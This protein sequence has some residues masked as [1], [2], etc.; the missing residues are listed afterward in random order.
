MLPK[1]PSTFEVIQSAL[2]AAER[3][4]QLQQ[5]YEQLKQQYSAV[6]GRY[7]F[8][9][10]KNAASDL[11]NRKFS[12]SKWEDAL[13]GMAGGNPARYQ[14]L[15]TQYKQAHSTLTTD[16][17][18]KGT[19]KNL[20]ASYTHQVQTNQTSATITTHEFNDINQHLQDLQ[21]LGQQIEDAG[22]NKNIKAA[23]D[24]NS[25]ITLEVGYIQV[26]EVRMMA[27]LN[28]QM[29]QTQS[30]QIAQ[31]NEAALYNQAGEQPQ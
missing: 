13:K 2:Q 1:S 5:Q 23:E 22:K 15:L 7:G 16:Q 19:D 28:Q 29:A 3:Y 9:H 8:G 4:G 25:R 24:L 30:S 6:T 14:Q 11:A 27:V 31:Q 21:A 17:Y 10:W 26:E 12:A 18:Q 20:A